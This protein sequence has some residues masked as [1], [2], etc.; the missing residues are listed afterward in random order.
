[1]IGLKVTLGGSFKLKTEVPWKLTGIT[2]VEMASRENPI[3]V[4]KPIWLGCG[5]NCLPSAL[6]QSRAQ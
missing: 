2:A 5:R 1:M 3:G 6:E 4:G